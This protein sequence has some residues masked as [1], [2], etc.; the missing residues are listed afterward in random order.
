MIREGYGFKLDHEQ[1]PR[2]AARVVA[3]PRLKASNSHYGHV[4][5]FGENSPMLEFLALVVPTHFHIIL[6]P[7]LVE[8]HGFL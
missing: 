8:E 6:D 1:S 3:D 5:Q 7:F 2:T 4:M